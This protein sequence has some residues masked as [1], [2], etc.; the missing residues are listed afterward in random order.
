MSIMTYSAS[1]TKR[2]GILMAALLLPLLACSPIPVAQANVTTLCS[3]TTQ[4]PTSSI[5][6]ASLLSVLPT[7]EQGAKAMLALSSVQFQLQ[8]SA[9][10]Q[11]SGSGLSAPA[12]TIRA[13]TGGSGGARRAPLSEQAA[14]LL[15]L[16]T[17]QGPTQTFTV[18]ELLM[19]GKLYLL[20]ASGHWVVLDLA[21]VSTLLKAKVATALNSQNLYALEQHVTVLDHGVCLF[22]GLEARHLTLSLA[23]ADLGQN[24]SIS[25]KPTGISVDLIIDQDTSRLVCFQITG[26]LQGD[27]AT[28]LASGRLQAFPQRTQPSLFEVTFDL[29]LTFS[30]F[31]Q[32]LQQMVVPAQASPIDVH[33]LLT[34]L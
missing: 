4:T 12:T 26:M 23:G 31:N 7:L 16:Q 14:T 15:T 18:S 21:Q 20:G 9:T 32:P 27:A 6:P 24:G 10:L 2:M 33:T 3:T 11:T 29:V 13:R 25:G 22:A 34:S 30:H 5:T 28:L 8:G 19:G 1:A 17:S